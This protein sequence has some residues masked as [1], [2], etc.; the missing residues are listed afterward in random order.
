MQTQTLW[1][2]NHYAQDSSLPGGTRH[3]DL[4]LELIKRGYD[5]TIFAS[6]YHHALLKNIVIYNEDGYLVEIKSKVKFVW[7][8]TKPY[9]RNNWKRML[10]IVSFA[11]KLNKVVPKLSLKKP[12]IIIGSTVH[13]FSPIV[14]S[15][16]ARIYKCKF[17]F[18][19]RD[20]WPQT[21][22]DMDL[23]KANSIKSMIFRYIEKFCVKRSDKIIVLS[24]LTIN[25]LFD[26]Y[27]YNKNKI[28]LLPNGVKK[29]II[30]HNSNTYK[31]D[32]INITYLGGIDK[33]HGLEYLIDLAAEIQTVNTIKINIYGE[34]KEKLNL[35]LRAKNRNL[36]N[37]I[38]HDSVLK[39]EVP[40]VLNS[41][42]ILFVSTANVL[43]GS[44][45]K[46]YDYMA[47]GNPIALAILGNHNNPIESLGCGVSLDRDNVISSSKKLINFINKEFENFGAIGDKGKNYVIKNRTT[48]ILVE[49]LV[50]FIN[51]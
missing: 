2:F 13:P 33:V 9:E 37:I 39:N 51:K 47:S 31:K 23:W 34:G 41:A 5:I 43:Y 4:A 8:K 6:G 24:P 30:N 1:F 15:K 25:Y 50:K 11:Y 27:R 42:S 49:K 17:I 20:L 38:W 36:S 46:L 28:L 19:I 40:N 3:F 48:D 7:I 44:E 10:N 22:I 45:N 35:K 32:N 18:E 12:D 29:S 26:K 14:A 21:F 16:F